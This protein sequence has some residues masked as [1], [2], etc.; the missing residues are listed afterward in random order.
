MLIIASVG[1]WALLTLNT[2]VTALRGIFSHPE[3]GGAEHL[4]AIL[5]AFSRVSRW[6][7]IASVLAAGSLFAGFFGSA[8]NTSIWPWPL[9]AWAALWLQLL[10]VRPHLGVY[11]EVLRRNVARPVGR[12]L[13]VHLG[14]DA[15]TLASLGSVLA[16]GLS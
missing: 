16:F 6:Q 4:E 2:F 14:F 13:A 1:L 10:W 8:L 5:A 15:I 3:T 7:N 9:F 12:L 11:V